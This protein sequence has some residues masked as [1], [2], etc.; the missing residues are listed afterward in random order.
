LHNG[1]TVT[2][3]TVKTNQS[4]LNHYMVTVYSL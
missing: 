4:V 2:Q 1:V 3:P